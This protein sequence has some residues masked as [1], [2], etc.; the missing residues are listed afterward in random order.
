MAGC[1]SASRETMDDVIPP[2]GSIPFCIFVA[3][4][5]PAVTSA[6]S[7]VTLVRSSIY[8]LRSLVMALNLSAKSSISSPEL[9]ESSSEKFPSEI[10]FT[11]S[12]NV[13]IDFEK[14]PAIGRLTKMIVINNRIN[15][16]RLIVRTPENT[17]CNSFCIS[18]NSDFTK[19]PI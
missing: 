14:C 17:S 19:Y 10:C 5:R 7:W 3:T 6:C 13:L 4:S 16:I 15:A 11:P 9:I 2:S 8:L 1:I 18:L 12:D